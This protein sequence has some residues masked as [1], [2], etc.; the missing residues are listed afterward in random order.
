MSKCCCNTPEE[1]PSGLKAAFNRYAPRLFMVGCMCTLHAI[2]FAGVA[3]VLGGAVTLGPA[4][5]VAVSAG[6][7]GSWHLWRGQKADIGEKR[8]MWASTLISIFASVAMDHGGH[9]DHQT[10]DQKAHQEWFK[11]QDSAKQATLRG[12]AERLYPE[13]SDDQALA[14]YLDFYISTSCEPLP[15]PVP[16]PK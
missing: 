3:A 2:H 12:N 9:H 7:L 13:L 15:R 10:A 16:A 14:R 6:I 11:A 1:K 5:G 8:F 4:V